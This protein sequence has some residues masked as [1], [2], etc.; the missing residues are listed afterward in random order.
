MTNASVRR[1]LSESSYA[2][3]PALIVVGCLAAIAFQP[4]TFRYVHS[5]LER[6]I[7]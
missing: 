2:A 6:L 4:S 7:Q 1:L 5:I 3:G